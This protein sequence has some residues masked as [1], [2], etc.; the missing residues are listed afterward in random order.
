[1]HIA[2]MSTPRLFDHREDQPHKHK[3]AKLRDLAPTQCT[4]APTIASVSIIHPADRD[5]QEHRGL[6][7]AMN[8]DREAC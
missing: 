2:P 3:P 5:R 6:T 8:P 4:I 7:E 1:M